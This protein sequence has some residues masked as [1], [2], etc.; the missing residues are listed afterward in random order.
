MIEVIRTADGSHS[1]LTHTAVPPKMPP[2]GPDLHMQVR[3]KVEEWRSDRMDWTTSDCKGRI[4][5]VHIL[6]WSPMFKKNLCKMTEQHNKQRQR[7]KM[8]SFLGYFPICMG[9]CIWRHR[10]KDRSPT[11]QSD[12]FCSAT[13]FFILCQPGLNLSL[14]ILTLPTPHWCR[15]GRLAASFQPFSSVC[16]VNSA[17]VQ[18]PCPLGAGSK[19]EN[20]HHLHVL[21]VSTLSLLETRYWI[22]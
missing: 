9:F 5:L 13:S 19:W 20:A 14:C 7:V 21:L 18:K 10:S 15:N 8:S 17:G 1:W 3:K 4:I 16:K 6:A 12:A 22:N 2:L 11:V